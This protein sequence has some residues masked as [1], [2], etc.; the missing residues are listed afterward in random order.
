MSSEHITLATIASVSDLQAY[1]MKRVLCRQVP[2]VAAR[3]SHLHI[4]IGTDD[5]IRFDWQ[6]ESYDADRFLDVMLL[7]IVGIR[8]ARSESR[9]LV[10]SG[11]S[12]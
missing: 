10:R 11:D 12:Q 1:R 9:P 2:S 8:E 7:A 4:E 3:A 5:E 6:I